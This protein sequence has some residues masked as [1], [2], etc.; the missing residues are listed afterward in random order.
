VSLR[1]VQDPN[2]ALRVSGTSRP[3]TGTAWTGGKREPETGKDSGRVSTGA[4]KR[5]QGVARLGKARE[6]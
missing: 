1:Q 5:G 3:P 4:D 2:R 6:A